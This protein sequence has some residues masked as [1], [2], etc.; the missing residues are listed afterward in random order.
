MIY[1]FRFCR[2]FYFICDIIWIVDRFMFWFICILVIKNQ[3]VWMLTSCSKYEV[4]VSLCFNS[5]V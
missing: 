4:F 3:S 1:F 5:M 2:C